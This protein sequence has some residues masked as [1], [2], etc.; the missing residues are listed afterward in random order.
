MSGVRFEL[1]EHP[2]GAAE[3]LRGGDPLPQSTLDACRTADAVLLGAMGLPDVRWPDG[4]E[5]TP[6]KAPP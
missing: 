2:C 3:Y 4:R 5:M 6:R 1:A